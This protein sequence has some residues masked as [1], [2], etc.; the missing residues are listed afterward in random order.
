M[1]SPNRFVC[2]RHH[3][4]T[5]IRSFTAFQP[6]KILCFE[7]LFQMSNHFIKILAYFPPGTNSRISS[8]PHSNTR[9]IRSTLS[10]GTYPSLFMRAIILALKLTC[11]CTVR[12]LSFYQSSEGTTCH[13]KSLFQHPQGNLQLNLFYHRFVK[14]STSYLIIKFTS[15]FSFPF[16]H[17][18]NSRA[19]LAGCQA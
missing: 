5:P 7:S 12:Y 18:T 10:R 17:A 8:T 9:Q 13:S 3:S 2:C 11:F 6:A 16:A 19:L 1:D 15:V 14:I 4:H